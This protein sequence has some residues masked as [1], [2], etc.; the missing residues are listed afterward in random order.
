M[1]ASFGVGFQYRWH[2][3]WFEVRLAEEN[4]A[5]SSANVGAGEVKP[6]IEVKPY[7]MGQ[8]LHVLLIEAETSAQTVQAWAQSKQTT[9]YSTSASMPTAAQA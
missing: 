8:H 9:L 4:L 7:T 1:T 6:Y 3:H 5:G 2:H